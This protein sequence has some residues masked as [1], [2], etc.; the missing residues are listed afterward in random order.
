MDPRDQ[1]TVEPIYLH[2]K[3]PSNRIFTQLQAVPINRSKRDGKFKN[4]NVLFFE[5]VVNQII[6]FFI[7]SKFCTAIDFTLGH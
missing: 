7:V 4:F 3:L 1:P 5:K 6:D 2:L